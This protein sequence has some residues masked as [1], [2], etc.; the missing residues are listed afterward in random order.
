VYEGYW[1]R[2]GQNERIVG[3]GVYYV[4]VSPH[5][6]GMRVFA[7]AALAQSQAVR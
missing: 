1:H 7:R 6:V 3:V 4:D 2:E 5:V